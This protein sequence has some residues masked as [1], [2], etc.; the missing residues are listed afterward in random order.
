MVIA[1]AVIAYN[2]YAVTLNREQS[3]QIFNETAARVASQLDAII[4]NMDTVSSHVLASRQIQDSFKLV[5]GASQPDLNYFDINIAERSHAQSALWAF[6]SPKQLVGNINVFTGAS[7]VGLLPS[8]SALLI[9]ETSSLSKWDT[10]DKY[11]IVLPPHQ[12]DW[13]SQPGKVVISLVRPLILTYSNFKIAATI[14]VQ[15]PFASVEA[16]CQ[17]DSTANSME[18]VVLD[19]NG[20]I[21]YQP[22]ASPA[23]QTNALLQIAEGAAETTL[24]TY[25]DEGNGTTYAASRKNL[26]TA[27]WTIFLLQD[28]NDYNQEARWL[29]LLIALV[30]IGFMA[31]TIIIVYF[32]TRSITQPIVQLRTLV[33]NAARDSSIKNMESVTD[34]NEIALL[35][36]AFTNMVVE[37]QNSAHSLMKAQEA[38]LKLKISELQAKINPHFLQ[39]ALMAISAAGQESGNEKVQ[40]MCFELSELFRFTSGDPEN[41][42]SLA[43]EMKV[44]AHYLDF[45]KYRYEEKLIIRITSE[46]DLQNITIPRLILQPLV[47]NCF[48]HGFKKVAP[49]FRINLDCR[50][51]G[52]S[53]EVRLADNGGGID[54]ERLQAIRE[55]IATINEAFFRQKDLAMLKTDDMAIINIY[56]RLLLKYGGRV[57]FDFD[58]FADSTGCWFQIG[59]KAL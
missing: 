40:T 1:A 30:G 9:K 28:I 49:P 57:V 56:I 12:D 33:N 14:E 10:G 55:K 43:E 5:A 18:I 11:Y 59:L 6:N 3:D 27:D 58:N 36:K 26:S 51:T 32:I 21:I 19:Q 52:Q 20:G 29:S 35:Q 25:Y 34:F 38:G 24:F 54:Q 48:I 37:I 50:V 45:M 15:V 4:F 7:F 42:V 41:D 44:V 46:G 53:W 8:P 23:Y 47:E 22:E 39:N 17:A 13:S 2:I 31:I 16:A